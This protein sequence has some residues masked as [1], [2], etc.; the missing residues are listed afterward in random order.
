M[1][2]VDRESEKKWK[3]HLDKGGGPEGS[4]AAKHLCSDAQD[5]ICVL[6]QLARVPVQ[7][8]APVFTVPV[9]F[10]A[11]EKPRLAWLGVVVPRIVR[12]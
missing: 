6:Q 10:M 4:S 8:E 11:A 2:I 1:C 7:E 12:P 9:A 3:G 5:A